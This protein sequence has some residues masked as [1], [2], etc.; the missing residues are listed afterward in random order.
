MIGRSEYN[1]IY[2]QTGIDIDGRKGLMKSLIPTMKKSMDDYSKLISC[3]PDFD[4]IP[5]RDRLK[6]LRS[7]W[8]VYVDTYVTVWM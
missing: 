1:E 2:S 5:Q 7:K 6:L 4:R 3:I 8:I